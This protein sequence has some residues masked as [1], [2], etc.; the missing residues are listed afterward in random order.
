MTP[1]LHLF[2]F[3]RCVCLLIVNCYTLEDLY[4]VIHLGVY[5]H[6]GHV[7]IVPPSFDVRDIMISALSKIHMNSEIDG[8]TVHS[9]LE[10]VVSS[11]LANDMLPSVE[12]MIHIH[13]NGFLERFASSVMDG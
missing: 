9:A 7:N 12:H 6:M 8:P 3:P 4:M 13:F 1:L 5:S 2:P 10:T 11:K